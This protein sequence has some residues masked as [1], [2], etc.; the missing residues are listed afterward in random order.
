MVTDPGARGKATGMMTVG[1]F[2]VAPRHAPR[3]AL[4]ATRTNA[5]AATFC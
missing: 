3:D 1:G 5:N 2:C 4:P